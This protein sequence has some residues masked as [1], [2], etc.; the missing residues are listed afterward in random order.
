[1]G[2][3]WGWREDADLATVYTV[4]DIPK[5]SSFT[6][7]TVPKLEIGDVAIVIGSAA[8]LD[9]TVTAGAIAN[10]KDKE[11][12]TTAQAAP[13]SSGGALFNRDGQLL[14]I[15]QAG[16]GSLTIVIPITRFPGRVYSETVTV[17]WRT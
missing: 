6:G 12:L 9:G 7:S 3:V 17:R 16:I 5:V 10:V 2:Y 14:G 13:G 8:G 1:M 15:V 11:I 4:C